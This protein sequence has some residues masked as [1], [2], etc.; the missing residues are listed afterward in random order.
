MDAREASS[1]FIVRVAAGRSPPTIA[2]ARDWHGASGCALGSLRRYLVAVERRVVLAA[3]GPSG[4]DVADEFRKRGAEGF[5]DWLIHERGLGPREVADV[6][7]PAADA[8][9]GPLAAAFARGAHP[10]VEYFLLRRGVRV[11]GINFLQAY[12]SGVAGEPA[13]LAGDSAE[14]VC[15]SDA[16][17][18]AVVDVGGKERAL[19]LRREDLGV[20]W[21]WA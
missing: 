14:V 1:A 17:V 20:V 3:D 4:L 2:A 15:E 13:A 18:T 6:L 12:E 8:V 10:D 7:V 16:A 11:A 19:T 21:D 9:R 5:I